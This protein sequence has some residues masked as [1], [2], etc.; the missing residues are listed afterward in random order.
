MI[1]YYDKSKLNSIYGKAITVKINR[2]YYGR[3]K[4][5]LEDINK[6]ANN[7]K[8]TSTDEVNIARANIILTKIKELEEVLV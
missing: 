6:L 7:I 8:A 4:K 1:K 2:A 5:I 3:R